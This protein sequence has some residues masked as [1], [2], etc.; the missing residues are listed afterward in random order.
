MLRNAF[1]N[2]WDELNLCQQAF[3][4]V[5][6]VESYCNNETCITE[7][8]RIVYQINMEFINNIKDMGTRMIEICYTVS[9]I[10]FKS[11]NT[12]SCILETVQW[13]KLRR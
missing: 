4:C 9:Y 13:L 6:C 11:H 10:L 1:S 2:A 8:K 12:V 5:V 7:S 3:I